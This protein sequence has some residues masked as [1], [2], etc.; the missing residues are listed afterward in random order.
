MNLILYPIFIGALFFISVKKSID[1][2][3][4]RNYYLKS[5]LESLCFKYN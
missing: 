1:K 2:K 3:G 4:V 5:D